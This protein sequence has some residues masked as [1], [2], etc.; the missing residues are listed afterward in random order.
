MPRTIDTR[1]F[2]THFFA[3]TDQLKTKTS[4][5]MVEL[6][7]ESA[8]VPTIVIHEICKLI[9][10]KLG[11]GVA[12]LRVNQILASSFKIVELT[13]QIALT[14][15]TLRHEYKALATADSIIAATCM[16]TKSKRV[17]SDDPHFREIREIRCE[18]L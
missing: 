11:K 13:T 9:L 10:D 4:R 3:D 16:E 1:F 5:K 7:R 15:A 6:Q 2:L 18:W 8:V 14:S 12:Q 17:L